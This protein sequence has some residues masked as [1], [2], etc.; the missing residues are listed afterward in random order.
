ETFDEGSWD[1]CAI[2]LQLARRS[3]WLD[4]IDVCGI[5]GPNANEEGLYESWVDILDDLGIPRSAAHAAVNGEYGHF[6]DSDLNID[7]ISV[8]LSQTEVEEY[9]FH[10]LVWL[11]EDGQN[12]GP[13]VV[14]AWIFALASAIAE[15][16]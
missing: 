11:W 7:D 15:N 13:Q 5:V 4:C 3:D 6:Y 16:C 9:F 2:E 12:C 8:F 10:Q 14:H 1:N